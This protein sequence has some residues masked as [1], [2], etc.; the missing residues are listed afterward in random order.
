[1]KILE[2]TRAHTKSKVAFNVKHIVYIEPVL[3]TNKDYT[4]DGKT[5]VNTLNSVETMV[6]EDYETIVRTLAELK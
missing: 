3:V 5:Y 6:K 4:G 1:M 2:L